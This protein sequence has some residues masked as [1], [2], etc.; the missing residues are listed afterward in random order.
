MPSLSQ[1]VLLVWGFF[2]PDFSRTREKQLEAD[3]SQGLFSIYK[4]VFYLGFMI[5]DPNSGASSKQ[6][7]TC[8][9]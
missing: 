5:L 7:D 9:V 2:A 1:R 4:T 3:R 6:I 8:G